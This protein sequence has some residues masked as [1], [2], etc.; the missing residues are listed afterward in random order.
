MEW[1]ARR[2]TSR[3]WQRPARRALLALC[4]WLTGPAA[5]AQ[6]INSASYTDPTT[7]YAHG[8]LGDSIEHATLVLQ[9]SDGSQRRYS[10]P[11]S[12][13]FEDTAPR[14][15]DVTGDGAPELITVESDQT[16][17][18]RLAVYDANGLLVATPYIGTRFRWLAPLGAADFDQ[19][20]QIELAYVDRPHLA[21]TLRVWRFENN[22][23]TEI[24][25]LVGLTNHRIGEK[26]IA[27][28]IRSCGRGPEMILATANWSEIVAVTFGPQ[29]FDAK[30]I[31]DDTSRASFARAMTCAF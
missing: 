4:L 30:A 22:S 16:L 29:G 28:G 2:P 25:S 11:E 5:S 27:G 31:S 1:E 6:T 13:V 15:V 14:L 10:L 21:K 24:G 7:R 3:L 19:D 8:V 23:L 12:S 17:G 9:L 20:G 18:A 26:D